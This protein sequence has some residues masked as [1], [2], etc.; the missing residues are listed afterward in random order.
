MS[1]E[2]ATKLRQ[3]GVVKGTRNLKLADPP[4]SKSTTGSMRNRNNPTAQES[5]SL[6]EESRPISMLLPGGYLAENE[7]GACYVLDH[8]YPLDYKH[9]S[10]ELG[11]LLTYSTDAVAAFCRD[12]RLAYLA[13]DEFVFLDTETT[14]LMGAGTFAFMV[15]VAFF[16]KDSDRSVLIVRQYFLRDQADEPAMLLFLVDLLAE[17]AGLITFNGR[18][19]DLPLLENRYVMQRLDDRIGGPTG[20]LISR[21]HI[22][23]LH[24]ARR[25]WRRRIGSCSLGALER[26]ILEIRRSQED[27]SG[28][29]IPTMYLDYLRS[30]DATELLRIFYHNK[31]DM[32]SMVVLAAQI[33]RQFDSPKAVDDPLDLL[34][35]ARW[36]NALGMVGEAESTLLSAVNM[37]MPLNHFHQ[38]LYDIGLLLKRSGRKQEAAQRW[39]QITSTHVQGLTQDQIALDAHIELAKYYEWQIHDF[40]EAYSWTRQ[41]I[42]L[43]NDWERRRTALVMGDLQHRIARLERKIAQSEPTD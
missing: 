31:I 14:G 41:A 25:L 30:G 8:V 7:L 11:E 26:K 9:G 4:S 34:S 1:D 29:M 15:G 18:A 39:Q 13:F 42:S 22:D 36:Q 3:L 37:E 23:L 5:Q 12:D 35:L 21:P 33:V 16:E 6:P 28:W 43:V 32:L 17:R 20:D 2:L 19:F 38:A 24:P 27:V 10:I 40:R